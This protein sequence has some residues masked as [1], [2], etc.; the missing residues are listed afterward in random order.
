MEAIL[1]RDRK[2]QTGQNSRIILIN[3]DGK[4]RVLASLDFD[5]DLLL[6]VFMALVL[7][8]T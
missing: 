3:E 2:P 4:K 6:R 5:L 8:A 1:A 7:L